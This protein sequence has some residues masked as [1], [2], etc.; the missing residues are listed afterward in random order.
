[1]HSASSARLNG[2]ISSDSE[3]TAMPERAHTTPNLPGK[4][5]PNLKPMEAEHCTQFMG[6][7]SVRNFFKP[8]QLIRKLDALR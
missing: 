8:E 6:E 4:A 7:L 2:R 1:M 3:V 5:K